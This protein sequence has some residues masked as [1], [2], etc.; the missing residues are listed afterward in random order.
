MVVT[1]AEN[2]RFVSFDDAK[3]AVDKA[4]N[5]N[6]EQ[7]NTLSKL[8]EKTGID[9]S[10]L[11][12]IYNGK[13]DKVVSAEMRKKAV[14]AITV[15]LAKFSK[16][17]TTMNNR[18]DPKSEHIKNVHTDSY[19]ICTSLINTLENWMCY[20]DKKQS[21]VWEREKIHQFLWL[22]LGIQNKF[23]Y[24]PIVIL[25][26]ARCS[27][28]HEKLDTQQYTQICG[29]IKDGI[30]LSKKHEKWD[31]I[32]PG[33]YYYQNTKEKMLSLSLNYY[34]IFLS[35][36]NGEKEQVKI[37]MSEALDLATSVSLQNGM[38]E[39]ISAVGR[40]ALHQADRFEDLQ[41]A[42]NS[43]KIILSKC[44]NWPSSIQEDIDN[45]DEWKF[46]KQNAFFDK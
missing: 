38:Y 11:Q 33:N 9:K 39:L 12:R 35:H 6:I 25:K 29:F 13:Q 2:G 32:L 16:Y 21:I 43:R 45:H 10:A 30:D 18:L 23:F 37:L 7:I 28:L 24:L 19:R 41:W 20:E 36:N 14:D 26:L 17:S 44:N 31:I 5:S 27:I 40:T 1:F 46:L 3:N 34:S 8:S 22:L 4:L 15:V 42:K